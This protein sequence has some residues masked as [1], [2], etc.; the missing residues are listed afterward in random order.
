MSS[1]VQAVQVRDKE[2]ATL[3][4]TQ[5]PCSLEHYGRLLFISVSGVLL[6]VLVF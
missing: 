6:S 1:N 3:F 5:F 4:C 2:L